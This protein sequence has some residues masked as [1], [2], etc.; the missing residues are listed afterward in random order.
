MFTLAS[1]LVACFPKDEET[2]SPALETTPAPQPTPMPYGIGILT[3]TERLDLDPVTVGDQKGI[4]VS[5]TLSVLDPEAIKYQY[6][7]ISG[8]EVVYVLSGYE[9]PIGEVFVSDFNSPTVSF[10]KGGVKYVC[11][12]VDLVDPFVVDCSAVLNVLLSN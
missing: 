10:T 7:E 4:S 11:P 5:F 1:L 9:T 6:F 2:P 12:P 8:S 3:L